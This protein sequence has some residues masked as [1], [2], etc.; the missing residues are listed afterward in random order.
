MTNDAFDLQIISQLIKN[1]FWNKSNTCL[2]KEHFHFEI[3]TFFQQTLKAFRSIILM[4]LPYYDYIHTLYI[5]TYSICKSLLDIQSV[6]SSRQFIDR[7]V[8][9]TG[10]STVSFTGSFLQILWSLQR[11]YLLIQP[12]F[13]HML[14]AIFHANR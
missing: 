14:S 10:V 4:D 12:F 7:S 9:V 3:C 6:F 8:D 11:S 13:G 5:V 2:Q 1:Q